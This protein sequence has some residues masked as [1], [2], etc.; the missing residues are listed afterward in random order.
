ATF[1]GIRHPRG[2]I[3]LIDAVAVLDR[4]D[5]VDTMIEGADAGAV[6]AVAGELS[7]RDSWLRGN[8]TLAS[9]G[10]AIRVR[11]GG[12]LALV[13]ST[14]CDNQTRDVQADMAWTDL[15]GNLFDAEGCA[16][17]AGDL[18]GDGCV[19][20]ADLGRLFQRWSVTSPS[21]ADLDRDGTVDTG[22]LGVLFANWGRCF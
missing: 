3:E 13:D 7:V 6:D 18:D 19:G 11:S 12:E 20:G 17:M 16:R 14:F 1:D 2:A 10:A 21:A 5:V 15:G 8:R 22:D 4:C 9:T